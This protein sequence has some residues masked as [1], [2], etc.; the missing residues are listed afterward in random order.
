MSSST[1]QLTYFQERT[2]SCQ[3][4]SS[5]RQTRPRWRA[6]TC[7]GPG[8]ASCEGSPGSGRPAVRGGSGA[9]EAGGHGVVR[10]TSASSW[11]GSAHGLG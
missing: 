3:S 11:A 4:P 2:E 8:I 6:S 5:C 1:H 10:L 9:A 7:P